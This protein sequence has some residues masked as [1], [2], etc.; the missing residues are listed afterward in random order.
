MRAKTE[1]FVKV[2]T[3]S[4]LLVL[5]LLSCKA[6]EDPAPDSIRLESQGCYGPCPVYEITMDGHGGVTFN[7]K[8]FTRRCGEV[9]GHLDPTV[10]VGF[11]KRLAV[12]AKL[13]Q[14]KQTVFDTGSSIHFTVRGGDHETTREVFWGSPQW[15]EARTVENGLLEASNANAWIDGCKE[16][17]NTCGCPEGSNGR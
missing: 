7:G 4:I 8:Q 5:A 13:P 11:A 17:K 2:E 15:E 12:L 6:H 9:T 1:P 14:E 3:H 16:V 10:F